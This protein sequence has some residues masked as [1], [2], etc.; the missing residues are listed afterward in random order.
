VSKRI[1]SKYKISRRLGVNLWGRVKDPVNRRSYA[2]GQHGATRRRKASDFGTQLM[3][4]QK[5]K[6]YYGNISEKQFRRIY[7]EAVRRKGDTGE[8]LIGLLESRLDAIVY[9]MGIVPTVFASRQFVGHG[10]VTVNGQRVNVPSYRCKEGDV[11]EVREKSRSI[12][13]ILEAAQA[14]ERE[15]PEYIEYDPKAFKGTYVR[16]PK[17]MDVPYP[18]VMEPNYIIEFYSR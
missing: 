10:H 8:N 13:M 2:P 17:L 3:E 11:I 12:P 6:G 1:A 4:K 16:V 5:L 15:I 9:R 7:T 14:V 18:V